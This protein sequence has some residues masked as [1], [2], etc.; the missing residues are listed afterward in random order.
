MKRC[1]QC[2]ETK[3]LK[4]FRNDRSKKDGKYTIC[5]Q[6]TSTRHKDHNT[7]RCIDC[8]QALSLNQFGKSKRSDFLTNDDVYEMLKIIKNV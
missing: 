5:K 8:K 4:N 6:C 7:K 2:K 1:N 3:L